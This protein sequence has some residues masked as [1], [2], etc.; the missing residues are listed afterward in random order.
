MEKEKRNPNQ[1]QIKTKQCQRLIEVTIQHSTIQYWEE[2]WRGIKNLVCECWRFFSQ[3]LF[4]CQIIHRSHFWCVALLLSDFEKMWCLFEGG[5]YKR[6]KFWRLVSTFY[7]NIGSLEKLLI[8]AFANIFIPHHFFP[9][10]CKT[11]MF[12]ICCVIN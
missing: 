10:N 5:T 8:Q 11:D 6:K 7:K 12:V 2:T 9:L 4:T 3:I 1:W